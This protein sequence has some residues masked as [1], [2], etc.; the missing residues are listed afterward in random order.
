MI[1]VRVVRTGE[2]KREKKRQ[3]GECFWRNT[4]KQLALSRAIAFCASVNY[5]HLKS[6][7]IKILTRIIPWEKFWSNPKSLLLS[8]DKLSNSHATRFHTLQKRSTHIKQFSLRRIY[9]SV[10]MHYEFRDI[11]SC[12]KAKQTLLGVGCCVG[13]WVGG[14]GM[15]LAS[16]ALIPWSPMGQWRVTQAGGLLSR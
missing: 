2:V 13:L 5:V 10:D 8:C 14:A 6:Y 12:K 11:F 4:G 7:S 1:P 16:W 3:H 9:F 15:G